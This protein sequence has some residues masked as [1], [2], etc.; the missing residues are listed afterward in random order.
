MKSGSQHSVIFS[1]SM[2]HHNGDV[3]KSVHDSVQN[4]VLYQEPEEDIRILGEMLRDVGIMN[5]MLQ[6]LVSVDSGEYR[7]N[8]RVVLG[9]AERMKHRCLRLIGDEPKPPQR[10]KHAR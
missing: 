2:E 7:G 4:P 6:S 3:Q 8:L 5:K 1:R 10:G 9:A